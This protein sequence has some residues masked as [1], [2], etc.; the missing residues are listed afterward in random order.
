[1]SIVSK[2]ARTG[3]DD[4]RL[5]LKLVTVG[6]AGLTAGALAIAVALSGDHPDTDVLVAVGRG[7]MVAIPIA[8][9]LWAWHKRPQERFGRLLV[10][11]GFAWFLTTLAESSNDFLYSTGRV[12]GWVVQ[13]GLDNLV[14][15]F[16]AGRRTQAGHRK[17]RGR[18]AGRAAP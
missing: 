13:G 2:D 14:L 1:M 4:D 16:P 7:V 6:L 10:A 12:A 9:G 17:L 11:A 5:T 8:V 15:P 3:E 18:A